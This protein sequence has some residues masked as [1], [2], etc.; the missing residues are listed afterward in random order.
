MV[1]DRAQYSA[2]LSDSWKNE[3]LLN[4][5]KLRYMDPPTFVD[6]GSIVASYSLQQTASAGGTIESPNGSALL[7][8]S[9][10][11]S[12]SPTIT[13]TPLTGSKFLRSMMTPLPPQS[14]FFSIESGTPAD[15]ILFASLTSIN[16]LRNQEP[17]FEG[18][19]PADPEFHHMRQLVR[20][21]Q[22]SGAVRIYVKENANK[23]TTNLL[24]FRTE[25]VPPETLADIK[26]L[27]QLLHLNQEA[28]EFKL[29][30]APLS[31]NDTEIAVTTR[32][33][34]SLM[35]IMAAQVEVPDEDLAQHRAYLYA[36]RYG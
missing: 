20:K 2:S 10:T 15:A 35:K 8:V 12:N 28:K 18:I 11:Y 1:R 19:V 4:I 16:G 26:E 34:L 13:Y 6:I 23:E 25:Q 7:G 3:T 9:G 17:T 32:S 36:G 29:V 27:R 31:S 21:I 5:V 33:V 30:F 22:L 24:T 14:I